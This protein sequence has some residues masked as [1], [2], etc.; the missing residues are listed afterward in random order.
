MVIFHGY[1]SFPE[2]NLYQFLNDLPEFTNVRS[3]SVC[4]P[5]GPSQKHHLRGPGRSETHTTETW[6]PPSAERH[7]QRPEGYEEIWWIHG[8]KKVKRYFNTVIHLWSWSILWKIY[9]FYLWFLSTDIYIY[10]LVV[11]L[12]HDFYILLWWFIVGW[13]WINEGF[14]VISSD[15][16]GLE[17]FQDCPIYWE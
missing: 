11:F 10:W 8:H 4:F 14:I 3:F 16:G 6:P 12:E 9:G 1:V 13:G 17:H 15:V 2:A 7:G 5:E